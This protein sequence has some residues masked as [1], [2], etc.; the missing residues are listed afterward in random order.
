[1]VVCEGQDT[2]ADAQGHEV[3]ETRA[4]A[5]CIG[6]LLPRCADGR[7]APACL[8]V[9]VGG[10]L[11]G[12]VDFFV[13]RTIEL[14]ENRQSA[15]RSTTLVIGQSL[16]RIQATMRVN[17]I[18]QDLFDSIRSVQSNVADATAF[19]ARGRTF[20]EGLDLHLPGPRAHRR[21]L[22]LPPSL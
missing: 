18:A 11:V 2:Q 7:G 19:V 1:M 17:V 21:V 14:S 15:L 8:P 12:T 6:S 22:P 10:E 9:E 20:S 3:V 5:S 13:T 4:P 16:E